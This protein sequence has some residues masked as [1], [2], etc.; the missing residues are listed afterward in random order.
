[1]KPYLAHRAG[2]VSRVASREVGD[3]AAEL[4]RQ[5]ADI[6]HLLGWPTIT[7][8]DHVIEAATQAAASTVHPHSSGIPELKTA[9]AGKLRV[10]NGIRL[11]R[12][13]EQIIITNGAFHAI[14]IC[15]AT[16]LDP[17]DEV[18]LFSPSFFFDGIIDLIGGAARYVPLD[19]KNGFAFDADAMKAAITKRTKVLLLNTPANP[20]GRVAT[21]EELQAI[22][23]VAEENDLLVISDESYE[24]M[25]YDGLSH[26]CIGALPGA[27]GR[28]ITVQSFTKAYAMPQWRVGYIVCPTPFYPE[29]VK[30]LEWMVLSCNYVAQRCAWAAV[31]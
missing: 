21:L 23:Q 25:V 2:L 18:L 1:M 14:Y 3:H 26:H 19:R 24:R 15:L 10:E 9:L 16:L 20:T 11:R 6:L 13:E 29:F 30:T 12:P 31:T 22:L 28:V 4:A 7:P 27:E 5:G 8:P 17:G